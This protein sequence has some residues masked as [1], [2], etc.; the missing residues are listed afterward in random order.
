M[1]TADATMERATNAGTANAVAPAARKKNAAR[2]YIIFGVIVVLAAA[3]YLLF[4]MLTKGKESTDN[5]QVGADMVPIA[6]RVGGML[7]AVPVTDNQ[8]VKKGDLLAQIDPSDYE[9]KVK[10]AEAELSAAQ[11]QAAAADAQM[12]IVAA[13]SKGGLSTARAQLS[14]STVSVAGADAQVAAAEA[15]VAKAR[16]DAEKAENDL[17]RAQSLR[18]D[19]AIPQAQ[20]D[21]L[22]SQAAAMRAAVAQAQANLAAAQEAKNSARTRIAEAAGRVEQS[23]PVDAQVAVAKANADLAAARAAAAEVALAQAKLNLSYTKVVAPQDGHLSKL[24]VHAGQLVQPSQTITNV[25]PDTTYV[26][27]NFKETQVGDMKVGQTAEVSVDAFPGRTFHAK[28]ESISYGT[29]AQ[30]SMLPPDNA[31]G[32]F[33]KVVQRVPVKL[34]WTDL[35][36]DVHPEA[37]LSADVTVRLK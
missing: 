35:P 37:G 3:G 33:V 19:D 17:R 36:P 10:Q 7:V 26:V 11:A 27:A 20:V 25:L 22:T 16:A 1:A 2:P 14:G 23:A 24:G 30:F 6:A 29:G 13:S 8:A 28:V 21:N 4:Q 15:M 34:V 9:N 32:N 18:K 31:S 5:A 12:K